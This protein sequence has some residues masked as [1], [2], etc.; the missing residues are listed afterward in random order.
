MARGPAPAEAAPAAPAPA[1]PPKREFRDANGNPLPP[2]V[3]RELEEHL[4]NNPLPPPPK[5]ATA[6]TGSGDIVVTGRRPRG[7][8]VGDMLPERTF[9]PQDVR[10]LGTANIGELL[11]AISPQVS[12]SRSGEEAG[13]ITLLNGRRISDFAEIAR[14]PSEAIERMEVFPEELA[15]KYGFAADQKVVNVVTFEHFRSRAVQVGASLPTDGGQ[16][17]GIVSIDYLAIRGDMR[18]GLSADYSRSSALLESERDVL[19]PGLQQETGSL[20]TLLPTSERGAVNALVSGHVLGD[21]SSTLNA[22]YEA[23]GSESLLGPG[24]DG[25]RRRDTS[26]DVA[27][28][29][30]THNGRLDRWSWTLTGN[31]DRVSSN[32]RTDTVGSARDE[33][34]SIDTVADLNLVLNGALLTLPAGSVSATISGSAAIRDLESRSEQ[35][36]IEGDT[37]L[38]RDSGRIQASLDVPLLRPGGASPLGRLSAN[39]NF[40]AERLTDF[41]T[42][43]TFGYGLS[44]SPS[45]AVSLIASATHQEDA[46]SMEQLGAPLLVTPGVRTYDFTRGEVVEVTRLF[47]GNPGLRADDRHLIRLGVDARPLRQTDLVL[48]F[49]YLSSRIDDPIA[50]FPILTPQVE[51]ALPGRFTRDPG[52][53]LVQIDARPLNFARSAQRQIRWGLNFSRS[54]GPALPGTTRIITR[55][56]GSEAELQRAIPPGARVIRAEPGSAIA[57]RVEN[58]A[59]RLTFSFYHS[60][61]LQDEIVVRDGFPTLDLLDGDAFDLRG[62]RRR[63]QLEFQAAVFKRGLGA[64]LSANWQD[65]LTIQGQGDSAGDL[66]VSDLA[67][68][69]LNLFANLADRFGGAK[70]PGWL[71][72]TRVTLGINNIFSSRPQVRDGAASVPLTYQPAYLD[73]LGRVLTFSLRKTF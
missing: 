56:Y 47:G 39:A 43:R 6:D 48:S 29:G 21:I 5:A 32:I 54:L 70:A 35:R 72:G 41:G 4:R 52:G 28:L 64:R 67:V 46:P 15:L 33:A 53:R 66:R 51:A 7:S 24:G 57:R 65:G 12:S 49:D 18:I 44:W 42:L 55:T 73:P 14:I 50:A 3:Q 37:Q 62:G 63:H 40:A 2:D 25:A 26:R 61:Q 36:G 8:V 59:S 1:V 68:V 23:S 58:M 38:S 20:R 34:R 71:K 45:E 13:P 31:F 22:R 60:W 16:E 19:Q 10:A 27:H 30:T 69:N 17:S 11:E 9:D